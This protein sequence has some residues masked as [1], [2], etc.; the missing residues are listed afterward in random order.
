MPQSRPSAAAIS[1][2][3]NRNQIRAPPGEIVEII[4]QPNVRDCDQVLTI[5]QFGVNPAICGDPATPGHP[6]ND[7]QAHFSALRATPNKIGA[8]REPY[9]PRWPRK[10]GSGTRGQGSGSKSDGLEPEVALAVRVVPLFSTARSRAGGDGDTDARLTYREYFQ[11][12]VPAGKEH[13]VGGDRKR[14][15]RVRS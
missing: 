7:N 10:S 9:N 4:G 8:E 5:L 1:P 15:S 14:G 2:T 12:A 13:H 11:W 6:S 3:R